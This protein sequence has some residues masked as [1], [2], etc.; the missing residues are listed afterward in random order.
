MNRLLIFCAAFVVLTICAFRTTLP[1]EP[2]SSPKVENKHIK[3]LTIQEAYALTKKKPKK[4]VVDVY[5]DWCGWC[6]V[7]DRETFSKPAIVDYVNENYYAVRLNAEQTQD[8][9]L[10]KETFKY[11]ST[12][13][14]GVH[15]LAAALLRNQMS[16]PT[17]VFLDEKFQLIQPIAGYLEPR[18]FHQVITYFGR[19]YHQ[20]EP[21]DQ[22]KAGTYAKEFKAS[23]AGK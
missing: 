6:K 4:F 14:R 5:T 11:V 20:K 3:W 17:T 22:Y 15:E 23:L 2:A 1:I 10:G 18:T 21:F 7:M 16:Y 19:D 12:G 13:G 8:I 9:T